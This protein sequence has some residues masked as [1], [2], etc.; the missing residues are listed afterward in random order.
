[1]VKDLTSFKYQ[2]SKMKPSEPSPYSAT[3]SSPYTSPLMKDLSIST[4]S[5][6]FSSPTIAL[7]C[8]SH[9]LS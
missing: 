5:A 2:Q 8:S 7:Q 4:A 3:A 6:A 9:T 1:M